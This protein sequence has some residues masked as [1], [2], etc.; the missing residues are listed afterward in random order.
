MYKI[1]D[2]IL[3]NQNQKFIEIVEHPNQVGFTPGKQGMINFRKYSFRHIKNNHQVII[4][5]DVKST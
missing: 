5:K 2:K 3:P 4:L 1:V